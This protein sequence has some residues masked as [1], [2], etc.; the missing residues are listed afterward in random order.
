MV[1]LAPRALEEIV[2]PRRLAG[3]GARPLNFTVRFR[4]HQAP[5][6]LLAALVTLGPNSLPAQTETA[7]QIRISGETC[8]IGNLDVP[9]SDVGAKLRELGT[10][11]DAHIHLSGNT[12]ASYRAT[13]AAIDSLRRA[14]FKL[15]MGLIN[16][17]PQ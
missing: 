14:G 17:Q 7:V 6:F 8:L 5:T 1:C 15:K 11:L 10:P 13:S 3:V 9:C 16:V 12:H 2:R 4:M